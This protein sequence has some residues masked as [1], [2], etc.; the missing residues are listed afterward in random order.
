MSVTGVQACAL[1]L[2]L[3]LALQEIKLFDK[4]MPYIE[5]AFALAP[6][7]DDL[8]QRLTIYMLFGKNHAELGNEARANQIFKE[9]LSLAE[10]IKGDNPKDIAFK[11]VVIGAY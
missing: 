1:P 10:Q 6:Q 4:A 5:R 9:T 8:Q 11:A 2:S 3:G 7:V